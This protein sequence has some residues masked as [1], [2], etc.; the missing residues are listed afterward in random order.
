MVANINKLKGKIV[1][2]GYTKEDFAKA[3]GITTPTLRQKMLNDKYEF[4]ISES[5]RIK[6]LLNLNDE[7]Y[8][9]IFIYF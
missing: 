3:V 4:T 6:N 5:V 9:E 2:H 7:D 1:E 8:L